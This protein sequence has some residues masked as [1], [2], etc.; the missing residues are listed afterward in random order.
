VSSIKARGREKTAA[1][2]ALLD[3]RD[4]AEAKGSL[5]APYLKMAL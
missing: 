3:P 2:S 1:A 5:T 4:F